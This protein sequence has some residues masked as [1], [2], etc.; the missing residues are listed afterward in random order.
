MVEQSLEAYGYKLYNNI[1][2]FFPKYRK[3]HNEGVFDA[4]TDATKVAR[5]V[6]LLTGL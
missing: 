5:T 1:E 4:Y 3:T 6:G 2:E